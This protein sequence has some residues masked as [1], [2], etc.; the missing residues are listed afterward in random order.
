LFIYG[1]DG[2]R[3]GG[4]QEKWRQGKKQKARSSEGGPFF[5]FEPNRKA[6]P[7]KRD[8]LTW[9]LALKE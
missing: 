2:A 5:N 9:K 8:S 6:C 4:R 3:F 7:Q 1:K